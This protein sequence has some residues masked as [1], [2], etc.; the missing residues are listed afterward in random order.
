LIQDSFARVFRPAAVSGVRL[1]G[2]DAWAEGNTGH[3]SSGDP[4]VAQKTSAFDSR[5]FK[6]KFKAAT[7][8]MAIT[9]LRFSAVMNL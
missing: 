8:L 9:S 5:R 3:R 6:V 7:Y 2:A 4:G 1:A